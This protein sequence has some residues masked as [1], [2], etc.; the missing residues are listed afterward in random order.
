MPKNKKKK[1]IQKG[2]FLKTRKR[3]RLATNGTKAF[4]FTKETIVPIVLIVFAAVAYWLYDIPI[5]ESKR[6]KVTKE[7]R[8]ALKD[9]E[10]QK[11]HL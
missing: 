3:I 7:L 2:P 1:P 6:K 4:N 5:P 10:S 8:K 9:P 11:I